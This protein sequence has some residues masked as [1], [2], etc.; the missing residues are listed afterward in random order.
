MGYVTT[1]EALNTYLSALLG[2]ELIPFLEAG[3][4]PPAIR[5]NALKSSAGEVG[6]ILAAYDYRYRPVPFSQEGFILENDHLPLSHTLEFFEGKF[7]YQ[8]ISSQLPVLV[9]NPQ[10]GE[11]VLDMTAA[12]GSKAS[13]LAARLRQQG[14]LVLNDSSY[15]RLQGLQANMQR[16]GARNFYILKMRAEN[17]SR[18]YPDFFDKILID[19]P[20]T[21]LGTLAGNPQVHQWWTEKKLEKLSMLQYQLLLSAVKCLKTG[22]ELVYSTCSV[23]PEENEL[24]IDKIGKKFP[25]EIVSVA[26]RFNDLYDTG[27]TTYRGQALPEMMRQTLRIW[28]QRHH[29]EGFFI[30]KLRKTAGLERKKQGVYETWKNTLRADDPLISPVLESISRQWGISQKYWPAW[31]F[32]LTKE[33]VWIFSE[34][35]AAVPQ[36]NFISAGILLGEKRLSGW[37]LTNASA[38]M[39]S[40]FISDRKVKLTDGDLAVLFSQRSIRN[41]GLPNGYYVLDYKN[42]MLASLFADKE[43]LKIR[44]PHAFRKVS[45]AAGL[46]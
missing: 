13:Q 24:V 39:L 30:A 17:L 31:R 14:L 37:K 29:Q 27:R 12:P 41:P 11:K 20:C 3:Q 15:T 1:N 32:V 36:E 21:A 38:Q 33:R 4:E 44:L 19:A 8:G 26:R 43:N 2:E 34:E 42:R 25:V 9:L 16:S 10:P 46:P 28:P 45:N 23:S 6:E 5:Y 7:Q 22:G 18:L 35:I 40:A